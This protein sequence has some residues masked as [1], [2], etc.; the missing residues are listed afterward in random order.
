LFAFSSVSL[1][2]K[3][4]L[5]ETILAAMQARGLHLCENVSQTLDKCANYFFFD[6]L[7]ISYLQVSVKALSVLCQFCLVQMPKYVFKSN[8]GA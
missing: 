5:A 4:G 8:F 3:G 7:F 6:L 2:M 1:S